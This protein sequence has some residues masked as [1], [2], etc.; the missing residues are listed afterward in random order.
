[1]GG[2]PEADAC[3]GCVGV[4]MW[5]GEFGS[6]GKQ[7]CVAAKA[8]C[9]INKIHCHVSPHPRHPSSPC[10]THPMSHMSH[11]S[12]TTHSPCSSFSGQLA[13]PP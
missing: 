9:I 7:L 3:T 13:S 12:L 1:M 4:L 5:C 6:D 2:V 10:R 8:T 11:M